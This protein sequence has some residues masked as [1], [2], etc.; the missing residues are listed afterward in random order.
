MGD[1]I[2]MGLYR[3]YIG[4]VEKKMGTTI[5]GLYRE[6][7]GIIFPHSLLTASK[8]S[9]HPVRSPR[10]SQYWPAFEERN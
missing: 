6:Y 2:I 3:G 4:I 8:S 5:M 10:V 9:C 1:Y 7:M